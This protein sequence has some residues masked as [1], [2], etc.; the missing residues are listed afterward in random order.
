M[1]ALQPDG[2]QLLCELYSD[3]QAAAA[4]C[5]IVIRL[6]GSAHSCT[7][8]GRVEHETRLQRQDLEQRLLPALLAPADGA[9][10]AHSTLLLATR[11]FLAAVIDTNQQLT[12]SRRLTPPALRLCTCT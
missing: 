1:L 9:A 4:W 12:G 8:Q 5:S 6:H 2:M 7:G 11:K 3:E 10:R